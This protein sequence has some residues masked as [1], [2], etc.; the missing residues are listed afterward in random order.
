MIDMK[1]QNRIWLYLLIVVFILIHSC[2]KDND[3][4]I[5]NLNI[6]PW[7]QYGRMTD[8]DGNTYKT[9]IIGTQTWMAENLKTTKLN[10][11]TVIPFVPD[12]LSWSSL[13]IPACCW[14]NN[15]PAR[16]V[17]YGVL[18]NWFTV[19]TGKL[20]PSGWH[21]PGDA[22]WTVLTDYLGGV[23]IA[24]AKLKEAGLRHW[25]Y[26]NTGATNESGFSAL[27]GGIR[28]EEP[29]ASFENLGEMGCWWTTDSDESWA[30]TRLMYDN[31]I[32]VQK[33]FYS[34]K[35]GLS[36]RCIRD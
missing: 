12:T 15:D 18:Y 1:M 32:R 25:N 3:I 6:S 21:V 29:D 27:P 34:K 11:G 20:C 30:S 19:N 31:G 8:Q 22:E 35:N 33:F 4:Y 26:P 7:K 17:T 10:D 28:L 5:V 36:V 16:K 13:S 23:N 24:G 14:Q 9:I 2:T